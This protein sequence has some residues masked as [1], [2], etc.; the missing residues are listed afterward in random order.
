VQ[1]TFVIGERT[2]TVH[3]QGRGGG[4]RVTVDGQTFD[5]HAADVD[6][7]ALSLLVGSTTAQ[8]AGRSLPAVVVAG[9]TP[10]ELQ[11]AVHGRTLPVQVVAGERSRRRGGGPGDASGPQRIIA[12]MPGK[13]VR[14]LVAPG[15]H[16]QP[17]QGLVVV[18]A[19]KME[20]ELRAARAGRVVSVSVVEGQSVDAGAVLAVV[21]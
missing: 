17:K 7:Q 9:R 4:Y 3:L 12:P 20:N 11:V 14:V 21:E 1:Y 8:G 15:D 6:G 2:R 16:V 5:V 10:G 13:V 19:M 18:E